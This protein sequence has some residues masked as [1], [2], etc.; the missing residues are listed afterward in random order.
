MRE[1]GV[2][3]FSPSG[4]QRLPVDVTCRSVFA[5]RLPRLQPGAANF[6]GRHFGIDNQNK[7]FFRG[8]QRQRATN[9][10]YNNKNGILSGIYE[11]KEAA[12]WISLW[13]ADF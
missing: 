2:A 12:N 4:V 8:S 9:G 13:T 3:Q 10:T 6:D 1:R 5:V 7:F 11:S